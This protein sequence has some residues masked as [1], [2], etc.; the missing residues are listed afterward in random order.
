MT[1]QR[2]LIS[3]SKNTETQVQETQETVESVEHLF[4][5]SVASE[6]IT[7]SVED[8]LS[9]PFISDPTAVDLWPLMEIQREEIIEEMMI[10]SEL[11]G[12]LDHDYSNRLLEEG[13]AGKSAM[14][15]VVDYVLVRRQEQ[16]TV[17]EIGGG[18]TSLNYYNPRKFLELLIQSKLNEIDFETLTNERFQK[19]IAYL[20]EIPSTTSTSVNAKSNSD[21]EILV[22]LWWLFW[23]KNNLNLISKLHL[24][25]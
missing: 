18:G 8:P 3:S 14:F 1:E 19:M 12:G 15:N 21:E 24:V 10:P 25:D 16:P 5:T 17:L 22:Y 2:E 23:S 7:E 9:G 20:K 4:S 6:I 13:G 11:F